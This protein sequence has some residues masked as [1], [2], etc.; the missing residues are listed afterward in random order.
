MVLGDTQPDGFRFGLHIL[1]LQHVQGVCERAGARRGLCLIGM[2]RGSGTP[3]L[4]SGAAACALRPASGQ[5]IPVVGADLMGNQFQREAVRISDPAAAR[6]SR[7]SLVGLLAG[8][9][10]VDV[11]ASTSHAAILLMLALSTGA[12]LSEPSQPDPDHPTP[13][14]SGLL[15]QTAADAAG[16]LI[17]ASMRCRHAL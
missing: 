5:R 2:T 1:S 6:F 17:T 3:A 11:T 13:R 7:S 4:T 8:S 16:R 12:V 9:V 15:H 10:L 14:A